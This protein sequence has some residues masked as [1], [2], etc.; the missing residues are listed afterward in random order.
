MSYRPTDLQDKKNLIFNL[1]LTIYHYVIKRKIPTSFA[2]MTLY[3]N[4][5]ISRS[6]YMP[7]YLQSY[8]TTLLIKTRYLQLLR[9]RH[10]TVHYTQ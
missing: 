5:M 7:T 2:R 4:N 3:L 6:K 1:V 8:I 10:H 9:T